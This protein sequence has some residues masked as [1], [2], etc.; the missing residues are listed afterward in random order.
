MRDRSWIEQLVADGL[1]R[2]EAGVLRTTRRWQAAMARAAYGL[3]RAGD[4]GDD[5]RVPIAAALIEL[6]GDHF[7]DKDLVDAIAA[8]AP[9][10]AG[11]L[12][13]TRRADA[14]AHRR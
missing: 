14:G 10:E 9:V 3:A 5:L 6:Y 2:R 11:E 7:G 12:K 4:G 1:L 13:S 8:I